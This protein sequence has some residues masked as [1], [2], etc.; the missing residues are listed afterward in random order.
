LGVDVTIVLP[1][2]DKYSML[3]KKISISELR[4]EHPLKPI[5]EQTPASFLYV[6]LAFAKGVAQ[7]SDILLLFKITPISAFPGYI[8]GLVKHHPM[9]I[10]CDDIESLVLKEERYPA[11]I[12]KSV[13]MLERF[14]PKRVNGVVAA[15]FS[16]RKRIIELGVSDKRLTYIPNGV[17]PEKFNPD[18]INKNEILA[19]YRLDCPVVVYVGFFNEASRNDFILL[20]KAAGI[21]KNSKEK[22]KF[23]IVGEGKALPHIKKLIADLELEESFVFTGFNEPPPYIAAADIA[24]VPYVNSPLHGGS[25]KLFEYMAMRKAVVVTNVGELPYHIE[26]GKTGLVANP[27]PE[28]LATKISLLASDRKLRESLGESARKKVLECYT[29]E[30][31]AKKLLSFC[32]SHMSKV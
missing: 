29:W 2:K 11:F 14:L 18:R 3:E 19:R 21:I 22:T 26:H 23:L 15:S 8:A 6:P 12:C 20:V 7:K 27:T 32:L 10:D 9:F 17:D 1:E 16:I 5:C 30:I 31:H 24:V 28:D 25:Q 13:D 4:L